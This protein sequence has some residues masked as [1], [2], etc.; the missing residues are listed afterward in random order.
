[1]FNYI[2][3]RLLQMVLILFAISAITFFL[4]WA[5]PANPALL[6]CGKD[7]NTERIAE[8]NASYGFDDP[9]IVQYGRYMSGIVNPG[10]RE[11]GSEGSQE[12]CS[13]PCLDR[14]LQNGLQVSD[15]IADAIGPTFWLATGAAVLWLV[16]GVLLGLIAA[17]RKGKWVDKLSVGLALFGVSFPTLV[18]GYL[19]VFVFIVKGGI[20]P[21]PDQ[22]NSTPTA[23]IGPFLQ[24]YI[25]PWVT[26]ALV[27]AALYT[28]LT[29]ANM[30]D[31]M[32]EDYIRTARAK[33][34][35]ERTVV[36]KH[37]LRAALTPIVTIFGLDLGALLGGAVITERI[38]SIQG[39]GKLSID[40]VLG[41][42]L[43]VVM[44]VVLVA[45][46]F[47]VFA[48]IVVDVLYAFIDPR[49]RLS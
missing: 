23:G 49:V 30:I 35:G 8:V 15:S 13:W 11:L 2:V 31:T 44:G 40:S 32:N 4:F 37:G 38:F 39:L 9:L 33:G 18:L 41:N 16:S 5:T 26:L 1:M 21:Y 10:G 3:R 20:L 12:H 28:R 46:F 17:L 43:P 27:N 45:A 25:L 22:A 47:V 29:R 42:D 24:F 6:I 48:N 14:S 19:L 34:L 36:F 7:C